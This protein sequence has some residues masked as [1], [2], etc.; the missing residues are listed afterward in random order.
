[1]RV[2]LVDLRRVLQS[3]YVLLPTL[4]ESTDHDDRQ[5]NHRASR[6]Y[7]TLSRIPSRSS[8]SVSESALDF[9]FDNFDVDFGRVVDDDLDLTAF[10]F[11]FFSTF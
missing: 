11:S 7:H 6:K 5:N 3:Q 10:F 8:S 2:C 1:M 9:A 4:S